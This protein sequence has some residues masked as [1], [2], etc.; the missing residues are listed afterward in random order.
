MLGVL[1]YVAGMTLLGFSLAGLLLVSCTTFACARFF[2]CC[3]WIGTCRPCKVGR[4]CGGALPTKRRK[5]DHIVMATGLLFL[6][7]CAVL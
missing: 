6:G 7:T 1:Q 4:Q 5:P 2:P 3:A